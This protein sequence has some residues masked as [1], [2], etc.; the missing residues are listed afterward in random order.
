MDVPED[1]AWLAHLADF[2]SRRERVAVLLLHD[3]EAKINSMVQIRPGLYGTVTSY[4]PPEDY[5][6][7]AFVVRVNVVSLR[8]WLH[9]QEIRLALR[10]TR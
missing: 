2:A 3:G 5:C 6:P 9:E 7:L 10:S 8:S 1:L 4:V